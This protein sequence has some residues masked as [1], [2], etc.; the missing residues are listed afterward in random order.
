MLRGDPGGNK[1]NVR[2]S[3]IKKN[4]RSEGS[5]EKNVVYVKGKRGG[6]RESKFVQVV[7]V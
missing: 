3:I 2:L 4:G 5:G 6:G 7:N 1:I